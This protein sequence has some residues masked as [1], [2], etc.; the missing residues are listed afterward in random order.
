[1]SMDKDNV[2]RPCCR[3]LMKKESGGGVKENNMFFLGGRMDEK[4][5]VSAKSFVLCILSC[6]CVL[7]HATTYTCMC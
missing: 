1:M 3:T 6:V 5:S 2:Y 7:F 4:M